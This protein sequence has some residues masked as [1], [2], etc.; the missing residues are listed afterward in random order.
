MTTFLQICVDAASL[1]SLYALAALGVGLLWGV[2]KLVNFAHGEFITIGA[3]ALIVPSGAVIPQL[4]IGALPIWLM[5]PT[6]CLIVAVVALIT[7]RIIFRPLRHA[8]PSTL[9][10]ASFSLS[11]FLQYLILLIYGGRPKS[12]Q[13]GAS[14]N[15]EFAF[16]PLRTSWIDIVTIST[17]IVLLIAVALFMTRTR[18]GVQMR[19]ATQ[20]FRMAR[21][22]GVRGNT[23]IATA[24]AVSG[25]LAAVVSFFLMVRTG[26]LA[27]RMAAPLVT[28]GFIATVI[29]G[30]GS[31]VGAIL[32]G[33]LVG[34]VSAFMQFILPEA[35]RPN[36]DAFVFAIV[37]LMLLVRPNGLISLRSQKERV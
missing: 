24:F 16:G 22:L 6:M 5:V 18:M 26:A 13:I 34:V 23:V 33:F 25:V 8:D 30:M 1:G 3:Y 20:D 14:L 29:G 11:F 31:M 12:I 2:M 37:I 17:T 15:G 35:M 27:P 36:R 19:A 32:G 10:V 7:E 21:M 9:L 28:I 4:F